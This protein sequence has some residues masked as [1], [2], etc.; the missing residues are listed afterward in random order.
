MEGS[1]IAK[2]AAMLKKEIDGKRPVGRTA[3]AMTKHKYGLSGGRK[4]V[5]NQLIV[6][7]TKVKQE[8][9]HG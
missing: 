8:K 1:D 6:L 2:H 3:Y 7:Q 5:Y 4:K 9:E